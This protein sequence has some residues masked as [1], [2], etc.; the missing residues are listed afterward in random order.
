MAAVVFKPASPDGGTTAQGEVNYKLTR[1][2]AV[3]QV[4][5]GDV[6]LEDAC[7]AHPQLVRAAREVGTPTGEECP[8]CTKD[9]LVHVTYVF[10]PRLPSHGRCITLRG[11][12]NQIAKRQ[13]TF[14]AYVVE[15]C[16][17]CTWNHLVRRYV[18]PSPD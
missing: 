13:G 18:L 15:C 4:R 14:V 6:A 10:G 17:T 12:I 5:R 3:A 11:E 1:Q 9:S 7:D 8:I 16:P 2:A